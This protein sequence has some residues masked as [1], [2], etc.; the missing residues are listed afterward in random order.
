MLPA[1]HD[2]S[3]GARG[4]IHITEVADADSAAQLQGNPLE[5]LKQGEPVQ[6]VVLG[7]MATQQVPALLSSTHGTNTE[8]SHC[9][10]V[11]AS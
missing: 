6:A 8:H 3:T 2:G 10:M 7:L 1:V 5:R 9:M 4:R 11:V